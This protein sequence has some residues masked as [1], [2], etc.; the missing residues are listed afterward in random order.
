MAA[1]V[2]TVIFAT[3]GAMAGNQHV[4][5]VLHFVGAEQSYIAGQFQR[6]F[7]LLGLKGALGGGL[8]AVISF[9]TVGYW[10]RHNIADPASDQV[11]ALFGTFSVG[12]SGYVGTIML[13]FVIA[14]LTAVTSRYTVFRHVGSLDGNKAVQHS[15]D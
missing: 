14:L 15:P 13:V 11:S 8:L 12:V 10:T 1:T 6:H 9:M 4:I 3:R 5:E 2:L 7:L